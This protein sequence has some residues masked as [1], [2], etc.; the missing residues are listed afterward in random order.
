MEIKVVT[1]PNLFIILHIV[2][3]VSVLHDVTR[4]YPECC[5]L[6]LSGLSF[7]LSSLHFLLNIISIVNI[8]EIEHGL[9][10][11]FYLVAFFQIG[12]NP[13]ESWWRHQMETFSALL[14]LCEGNPPAQRLATRS[15]DVFFDLLLNNQE[16]RRWFET[17]SCSLW[18]HC[19]GLH[20]AE[21]CYCVT[22]DWSNIGH[23]LIE[24]AYVMTSSNINIFRVTGL[25]AGNSPVPVNSPHKGQ[26]RG[27]LMFSLICVS[28]NGWINNREAGDLRRHRGHYDVSVMNMAARCRI[29]LAARRFRYSTGISTRLYSRAFAKD[30][31]SVKDP[32]DCMDHFVPTVIYGVAVLRLC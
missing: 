23:Y 8:G 22:H 12:I 26:W 20:A 30:L 24:L 14:V 28:I 31:P 13:A 10:S 6:K 17:P 27:A 11:F 15:F 29:I 21:G 3:A 32:I 9:M 7:L 4:T 1:P 18:R 16:R 25:C 2:H 5:V 19:N